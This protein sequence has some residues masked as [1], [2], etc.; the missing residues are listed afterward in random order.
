MK[1]RKTQLNELIKS[2]S[3]PSLLKKQAEPKQPPVKIPE[4]KV[5]VSKSKESVAK[6]E[7]TTELPKVNRTKVFEDRKFKFPIKVE[8]KPMKPISLIPAK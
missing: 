5:H 1:D 8:P 6:I 3:V 4:P 2:K 7:D